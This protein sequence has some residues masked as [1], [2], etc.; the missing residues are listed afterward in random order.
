MDVSVLTL[1]LVIAAIVL[2]VVLLIKVFFGKGNNSDL[3]GLSAQM[4]SIDSRLGDEF[5][6]NREEITAAQQKMSEKTE[7]KLGEMGDKINQLTISNIEQQNK[8]NETVS[9]RLDSLQKSNEEKLDKM[10]ETVDEKLSK[11]L[12]DRLDTSFKQVSEQLENVYKSLGEV[13][14][15]SSGVTD[16]ISAL[17]RVLTNVKARGTWAEVQLGNILDQTIPGM[18]DTNIETVKG[19]GERV[20]F[21]VKVP[22][23]DEKITDLYCENVVEKLT[24]LGADIK[25]VEVKDEKAVVTAG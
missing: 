1:V 18:Y 21:A 19:S 14:T 2:L 25:R 5:K 23:D 17:N 8:I 6:R 11:T 24:A 22:N 20:E 13:K 16:N 4:R 10:R 9:R 12:N 3:S 15:L 7:Q